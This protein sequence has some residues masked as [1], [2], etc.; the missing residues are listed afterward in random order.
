MHSKYARQGGI[1]G[2]PVLFTEIAG[3][4]YMRLSYMNNYPHMHNIS[5]SP[6]FT[7]FSPLFPATSELH[8]PLLSPPPSHFFP[9]SR[10]TRQ[11]Q[12]TVNG[13][14]KRTEKRQRGAH[15]L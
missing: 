10:E 13:K 11:H 6:D 3:S 9:L 8:N 14:I 7:P 2:R 12:I 5:F 15:K 4:S 1:K